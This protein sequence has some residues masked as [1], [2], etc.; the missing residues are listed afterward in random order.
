M[1]G[2]YF[3]KTLNCEVLINMALIKICVPLLLFFTPPHYI[4]KKG[5][6]EGEIHICVNVLK[7][8]FI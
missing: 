6:V 4:G 5:Y 3:L 2:A 7:I 8:L 1:L